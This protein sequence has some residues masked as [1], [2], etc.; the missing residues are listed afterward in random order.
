[1]TRW[2]LVIGAVS[3]LAACATSPEQP[4]NAQVSGQAKSGQV[5]T[6]AN[7]EHKPQMICT[8]GMAMGSHIP[9][10]VCVTAEQQKA[11]EKAD[12][13]AMRNLQSNSSS[14]SGCKPSC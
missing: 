5:A 12:Q 4:A 2:I 11:R 13:E 3:V 1:M 8:E 9:Q 10:R 7:P 14:A 6:A